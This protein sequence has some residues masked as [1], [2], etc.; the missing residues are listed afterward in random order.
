[1]RAFERV[2]PAALFVAG[3][4]V[5][6]LLALFVDPRMA[7]RAPVLGAHLLSQPATALAG[8]VV[9]LAFAANAIPWL[10]LSRPWYA[11]CVL[12]P[13]LPLG[14]ALLVGHLSFAAVNRQAPSYLP[15]AAG[16]TLLLAGRLLASDDP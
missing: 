8:A 16:I 4:V 11:G 14:M 9:L 7:L 6:L 3:G 15:W 2:R 5:L 13:W 12:I 10:P 1:M